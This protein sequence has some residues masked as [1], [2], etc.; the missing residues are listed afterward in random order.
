MQLR[1]LEILIRE[2]IDRSGRVLIT[3][4][5]RKAIPSVMEYGLMSAKNLIMRKDLLAIARPDPDERR[6]WKKTVRDQIKQGVPLAMG[7]NAY[8]KPPPDDLTLSNEHPSKRMDLVRVEIDLDGL[9]EEMP[10]TKIYGME[11]EPFPYSEDEWL[12]MSDD[13][14]DEVMEEI[15]DSRERFISLDELDSYLD[16]SQEELWAHYDPSS[17]LYAG[18]VPHVAIVT[19][20]GI[21]PPLFLKVL[22]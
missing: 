6:R 7:P 9:M 1:L 16:R 4:V 13:E 5:P 12:S 2:M 20:T 18:D 17:P 21:I 19:P 14:K 10:S 8:V 15:G 22:R 11:L 3:E